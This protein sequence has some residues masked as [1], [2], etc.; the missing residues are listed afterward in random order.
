VV[1]CTVHS[2]YQFRWEVNKRLLKIFVMA[3]TISSWASAMLVLHR[4]T[5][6]AFSVN[7]FPFPSCTSEK[8]SPCHTGDFKLIES[9]GRKACLMVVTVLD[10][11]SFLYSVFYI[12]P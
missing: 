10:F 4:N 11:L 7:S 6:F 12:D 3:G 2:N 9:P 5:S 1:R 8:F